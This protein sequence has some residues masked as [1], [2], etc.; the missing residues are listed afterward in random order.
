MDHPL[1]DVRLA[2]RVAS[3][4]RAL[5]AVTRAL[6][7]PAGFDV[8]GACVVD[9]LAQVYT[10]AVARLVIRA[11]VHMPAAYGL[12]GHTDEAI[13]AADATLLERVASSGPVEIL[14]HDGL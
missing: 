6:A 11:P 1:Q 5:L 14:Q 9:A 7:N 13:A 3:Q 2:D 8:L 12:G 10:P 4:R